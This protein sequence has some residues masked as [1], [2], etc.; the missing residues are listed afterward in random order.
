MLLKSLVVFFLSFLTIITIRF[1]RKYFAKAYFS[2]GEIVVSE[3]DVVTVGGLTT[4]FL[5]PFIYAFLLSIVFRQDIV[6]FVILYGFLASFL[7]VWPGILCPAEILSKEAYK[8]R[9]SLYFIYFVYIVLYVM[10]SVLGYNFYLLISNTRSLTTFDFLRQHLDLNL[11]YQNVISGVISSLLTVLLI[12]LYKTSMRRFKRKVRT[13][14]N[15]ADQ[16]ETEIV[17]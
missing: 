10:V 3:R 15:D 14:D 7:V 16:Q 1:I 2:L 13:E 4:K 8:K 12:R 9:N 11:L 17:P 6:D 5:P